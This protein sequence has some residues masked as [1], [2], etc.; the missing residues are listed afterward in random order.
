MKIA[1][2]VVRSLL[3]AFFIFFGLN[4]FFGW[5]K[6]PP[7]PGEGGEFLG[8]LFK[9]GYLKFV[10]VLEVIG[11]VLLISGQFVPLGL[12]ILAPIIVNIMAFHIMFDMAGLGGGAIATLLELFL[13]WAYRDH[14]RLLLQR[15]ADIA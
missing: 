6:P 2:L 12:V 9:T 1:V 5:M 7:V 8:V 4:A 3:G 10:K 13:I 11:G 15:N 14:F